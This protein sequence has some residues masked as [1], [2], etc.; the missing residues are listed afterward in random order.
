MVLRLLVLLLLLWATLLLL[1]LLLLLL[2]LLRLRARR[3]LSFSCFSNPLRS[4]FLFLHHCRGN[5]RSSK[6]WHS[7][8]NGLGPK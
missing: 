8:N 3:A 1:M 4:S 2:L 7:K 5:K 6:E